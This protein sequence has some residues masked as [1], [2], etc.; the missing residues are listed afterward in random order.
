[1]TFPTV[2]ATAITNGS[3]SAVNKVC[4]LPSGIVSGNLLILML[5]SA[6]SPGDHSTPAGWTALVLNDTSD[7][8]DDTMSIWYRQADGNEGAT[9]TV[10]GVGNVKFAAISYRISGAENPTTQTPEISTVAFG[11]STLPDPSSLTPTGGAKDYLW[12]WMGG[13]D[14][15]TTSPPTGNPTNYTN[16]LGADSGTLGLPVTN[17]RVAT[18]KRQLNASSEDP[19]SWTISAARLW[20]AWT[21]AIHPAPAVMQGVGDGLTYVCY[22]LAPLLDL[23]FKLN[24]TIL[25]VIKRIKTLKHELSSIWPSLKSFSKI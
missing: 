20:S 1:M 9:V 21:V 22:A 23:G 25:S 7:A 17:C 2:E 24:R 19:P 15:E 5:R 18:A 16:P 10:N 12:L 6:G 4:N 11:D 3:T 13:W 8:A 14:G